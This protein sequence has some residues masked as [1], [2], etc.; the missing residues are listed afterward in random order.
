MPLDESPGQEW[1]DELS[2]CIHGGVSQE[3]LEDDE[4]EDDDEEAV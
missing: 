4:A 3:D 2:D 1:E